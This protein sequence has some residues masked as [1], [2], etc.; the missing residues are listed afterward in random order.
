LQSFFQVAQLALETV[1]GSADPLDFE[2]VTRIE[3]G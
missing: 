1:L 3:I 2:A